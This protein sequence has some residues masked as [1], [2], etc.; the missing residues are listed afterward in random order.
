MKTC[1]SLVASTLL[2]LLALPMAHAQMSPDLIMETYNSNISV[3]TNGAIN[4]L[5]SAS[6]FGRALSVEGAINLKSN[7]VVNTPG[8]LPVTLTKFM[9]KKGEGRTALIAWATTEEANSGRFEI[10]RSSDGRAWKL[11]ASLNAKG[12]SNVLSEY[13]YTDL[14]PN[15]GINLYR[16]KMTDRDDSFAYSAIR[17]IEFATGLRAVLYPNPVLNQLTLEADNTDGIDRFELMDMNG[18]IVYEQVRT[19]VSKLHTNID[20]SFLSSGLYVGRITSRAGTY[21]QKIL[22]IK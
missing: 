5:E 2:V 22:K 16:L 13:A 10:E 15:A 9:L 12:E 18:K 7:I 19:P 17:S 6:L 1:F 21:Y 20:V 11:V 8:A 4:L 3:I 14:L